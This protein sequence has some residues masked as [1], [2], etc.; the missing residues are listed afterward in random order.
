[1][2]NRDPII[3]KEELMKFLA[4]MTIALS[5]LCPNIGSSFEARNDASCIRG[6]QGDRLYLNADRI[7]VNSDGISIL[8]DENFPHP[9]E[10][11][12]VD[13]MGVYTSI[14][15]SIEDTIA[16]VWNIVWCRNCN[17]YRS[18]DMNGLCMVCGKRP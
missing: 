2:K 4:L 7:Q 17:K 16:T 18:T 1:M 8:D 10:N 6:S 3:L 14:G 15:E 5:F 11:I 9:L 12:A 13:S